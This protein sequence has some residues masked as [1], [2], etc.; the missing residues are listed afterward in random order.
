MFIFY[1]NVSYYLLNTYS[2]YFS[3]IL[4]LLAFDTWKTKGQR[5]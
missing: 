4:T 3:Y 1:F 2:M 5:Y